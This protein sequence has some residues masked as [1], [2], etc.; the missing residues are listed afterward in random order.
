MKQRRKLAVIASL[1]AIIIAGAVYTTTMANGFSVQEDFE[2]VTQSNWTDIYKTRAVQSIQEQDGNK[3]LQIDYTTEEGT[4]SYYDVTPASAQTTTGVIQ[5]DFDINFP[6]TSTARNGQIQIKSRTGQGSSQTQIASRLVKNYYY[7]EYGEASTLKTLE[8][9]T[10]GYF[11]IV[12]DTWYKVK[13]IVNLDEHWQ[14][15]YIFDRTGEQLLALL[16][17]AALNVELDQI[18]MVTFSGSTTL[19]LDNVDIGNVTTESGF[20]YGAPYAQRPKT[21]T[22]EYTY[23]LLGQTYDGKITAP[24]EAPQWSLETPAEG[25]SID[26]STGKLTL[27]PL[28]PLKKVI[29]KAAAGQQEYRFA[30][31]IKD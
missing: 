6:E 31:D 26:A 10:G 27:E 19:K 4:P 15:I 20:I 9:P 7:L 22:S 2:N 13:M 14:S 28:A 30:V 29:I 21:G 8:K 12:A 24:D 3:Y 17:H 18:N 11:K 23:H 16:E 1:L 5:A 25:V